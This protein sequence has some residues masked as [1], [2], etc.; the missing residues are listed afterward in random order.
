M[1][2]AV[3]R[4][5]L[6]GD[7]P[8]PPAG[9]PH[10]ADWRRH[11]HADNC[12]Q[13]RL[14]GAPAPRGRLMQR[15]F[16]RAL[17]HAAR[18]RL[19]SSLPA[20]PSQITFSVPAA[21]GW[22]AAALHHAP[23]NACHL[24]AGTWAVA[25][26]S[27]SGTPP[28][29]FKCARASGN[30]QATDC[31]GRRSGLAGRR[32]R[33]CSTCKPQPCS[34]CHPQLVRLGQHARCCCW[35]APPGLLPLDSC[36]R[37]GGRLATGHA[38]PAGARVRHRRRCLLMRQ[39]N[40]RGCGL[41]AK[42]LRPSLTCH[43]PQRPHSSSRLRPPRALQTT[44]HPSCLPHAASRALL[45]HAAPLALPQPYLHGLLRSMRP[46]TAFA[47]LPSH[48]RCQAVHVAAALLCPLLVPPMPNTSHA[49]TALLNPLRPAS[50]PELPRRCNSR[51][52]DPLPPRAAWRTQRFE[53]PLN[54]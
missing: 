54:Y 38:A 11:Q 44:A 39:L 50:I 27:A 17:I 47:P 18:P 15:S 28:H 12:C 52:F 45:S 16:R 53:P 37:A 13:W 36:D 46:K 31:R 43:T 33:V 23:G 9:V 41:T 22:A 19:P 30:R 26:R 29:I 35:L 14:P 25:V 40:P 49:Q 6:R 8:C 51:P 1:A 24:A 7:P 10:V 42:A 48:P 32:C 20:L 21:T 5:L 4:L 2:A 3:A 34:P